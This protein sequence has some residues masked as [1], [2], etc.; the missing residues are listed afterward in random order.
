[1]T[2]PRSMP[3]VVVKMN[4][5]DWADLLQRYAP[6][7]VSVWYEPR[8]GKLKAG[9][10]DTSDNDVTLPQ[11]QNGELCLDEALGVLFGLVGDSEGGSPRDA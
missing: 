8:T 5:Y 7:C 10:Q 3:S 6:A 9:L 1:M 2:R 11:P 4:V